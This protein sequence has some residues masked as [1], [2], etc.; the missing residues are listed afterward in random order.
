MPRSSGGRL[1]SEIGVGGNK[2]GRNIVADE[3][4]NWWTS[5]MPFLPPKNTSPI[6]TYSQLNVNH[7]IDFNSL[8]KLLQEDMY[9]KSC[10]NDFVEEYC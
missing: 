3:N 6:E 10:V 8:S 5:K 7:I 9:C 2:G 4:Q 1:I